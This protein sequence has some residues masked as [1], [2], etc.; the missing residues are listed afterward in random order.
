MC[1]NLNK[2]AHLCDGK[3]AI[4]ETVR[5]DDSLRHRIRSSNA[6]DSSCRHTNFTTPMGLS[7]EYTTL[8]DTHASEKS[9]AEWWGSGSDQKLL[10]NGH[11][12]YLSMSIFQN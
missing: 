1:N 4:I 6:N 11:E 5:K 7:F 9:L 10:L 8:A 12:N 3:H 2:F